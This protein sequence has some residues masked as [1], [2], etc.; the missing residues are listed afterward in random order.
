MADI[1]IEVSMP[2]SAALPNSL[3]GPVDS[4]MGD[5]MSF[6]NLAMEHNK[7]K[8]DGDQGSRMLYL[9]GDIDESLF[10]LS[11]MNSIV[12][13]GGDIAHYPLVL[14]FA[15]SAT[16][17][18]TDVHDDVPNNMTG[19]E[20]PVRKKWSQWKT[21]RRDHYQDVGGAGK[22]YVPTFSG[23]PRG[24]HLLASVVKTLHATAEITA[25]LPAAFKALVD[26][27]SVEKV[28]A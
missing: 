18:G 9:R 23:S 28:P 24:E 2:L 12:V 15:S 1:T 8:L 16:Y 10:N 20:V 6:L 4:E 21:S 26:A 25:I 19:D 7:S 11:R 13:T 14:Q 3:G 17:T 5:L 22:F 27:E